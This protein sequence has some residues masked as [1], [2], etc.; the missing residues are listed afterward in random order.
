M[1][2]SVFRSTDAGAPNITGQI[3]STIS[4]LDTL[5]IGTAGIAYG[6]KASLGWT[7][8]YSATNKAVYKQPA[9]SNGFYLD[10]DDSFATYARVRA[11][12]TMTAVSTGDRGFPAES[13]ASGGS[14][15]VKS[16][17]ADSVQRPWLAISNGKIIYLFI[18]PASLD[19]TTTVVYTFG[20][21][22]S[23]KVG[24]NFNTAC[25][26]NT[27]SSYVS[28]GFYAVNVG[29][30][31]MTP[32]HYV[33]RNYTQLGSSITVGKHSDNIKGS[34]YL[35]TG[36]LPYPNPVDGSVCMAPIWVT[37]VVGGVGL[38]RGVLPG[39]WNPLHDRPL[40]GGATFAGSGDFAGKT[41][42]C[43]RIYSN[44]C[45]FIETSDTW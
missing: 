32:G 36:S 44:G 30:T 3:G 45:V 6:S 17:S 2:V 10:V 41:F 38:V 35:G 24:D 39:I 43:C 27:G 12:E 18:E 40:P 9:G 26:M 28:T 21:F 31:A 4:L 25:F 29:I 33:A 15:L 37:E 8:P 42:E 23:F 1:T 19:G 11:F 5:L 22:T 13:Q 16:S 7:K 14:Y 34:N 20:D